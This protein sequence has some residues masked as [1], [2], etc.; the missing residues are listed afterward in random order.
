MLP[1]DRAGVFLKLST[2]RFL[3]SSKGKDLWSLLYLE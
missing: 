2:D 3:S 1:R